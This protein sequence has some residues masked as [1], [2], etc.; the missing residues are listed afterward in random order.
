[1]LMKLTEDQYPSYFGTYIQLVPEGNIVDMLTQQKK[2]TAEALRALTETEWYYRYAPEKWTIKEVIGH[3]IDTEQ[4]MSYRLLCAA[5]GD[6]SAL[7]PF[8]EQ[9]Y[10]RNA[11]YE[12]WEISDLIAQYETTRTSTLLLIKN[13][14]EAAWSRCGSLYQQPISALAL[15][16][17]IAGHERHHWN[18]LHERYEV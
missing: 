5:R 16:H 12:N 1:M 15:A 8:D 2:E 10:G 13:L 7:P 14:S 6:Q 4:I 18:V 17:I 11:Q 9:L 3:I